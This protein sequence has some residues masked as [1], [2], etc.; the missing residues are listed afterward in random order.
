MV[1]RAG[2]D[3]VCKREGAGSYCDDSRD[4]L[5]DGFDVAVEESLADGDL[6]R[7]EEAVRGVTKRVGDVGFDGAGV[8]S[9]DDD[10]L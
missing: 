1:K 4:G 5:E 6:R 7:R 8:G 3:G 10:Q 9:C 2:V